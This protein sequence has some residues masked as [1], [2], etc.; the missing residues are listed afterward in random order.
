MLLRIELQH[1][2]KHIRS[3]CRDVTSK[4]ERRLKPIESLKPRRIAICLCDVCKSEFQISDHVS[5]KSQRKHHFCSMRCRCVA[6]KQDGVLYK[7]HAFI[8]SDVLEKSLKA[9]HTPEAEK[10]RSESL[11]NYHANKPSDW[12]NPGNSVEACAKRHQTMKRNG[13]YQKSLPEDALYVYLCEKH[14]YQN[15]ERNAWVNDRWPIDFYIKDIDTYVQLDGVYWHGLN[16]PIEIIAA[17]KNKRDIVIHRKWMTDREQDRW[18]VEQ[19][20]KLVRLTDLEFNEG[21]R[22]C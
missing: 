4:R 15:V 21:K 9:S 18:F 20:M 17:Y 19:G 7:S 12:Q 10:K 8:R 16:R 13:T 2:R 11:R 14:G 3:D 5:E 22:P 1:H 6:Q